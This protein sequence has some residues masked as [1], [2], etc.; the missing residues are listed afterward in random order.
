LGGNILPVNNSHVL[1]YIFI[2]ICLLFTNNYKNYKFEYPLQPVVYNIHS[3]EKGYLCY[4]LREKKPSRILWDDKYG[5][6]IQSDSIDKDKFKELVIA[7]T[8]TTKESNDIIYEKHFSKLIEDFLNQYISNGDNKII[9]KNTFFDTFIDNLTKTNILFNYNNFINEEHIIPYDNM[10]IFFE[11]YIY[12]PY[13]D[14]ILSLSSDK[15]EY[16]PSVEFVTTPIIDYYYHYIYNNYKI[17]DRNKY[18]EQEQKE[19]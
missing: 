8:T 12:T 18:F 7:T 16:I 14:I 17:E 2:N 1:K 10:D 13:Y 4:T 19:E 3:T 5:K 15:S 11:K 9:G 6:I